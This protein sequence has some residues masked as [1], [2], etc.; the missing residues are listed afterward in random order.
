[1]DNIDK[2]KNNNKSKNFNKYKLTI[3][4]P[5]ETKLQ[6]NNIPLVPKASDKNLLNNNKKIE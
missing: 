4:I 5:N 2:K 1:M 6:N 3:K